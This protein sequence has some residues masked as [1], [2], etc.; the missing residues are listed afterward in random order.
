MDT[1]KTS[2]F[3]RAKNV[4]VRNER[5]IL[6]TVTAVSLTANVVMRTGISQHNDFL[7]EHGLYD[8]FYNVPNTEA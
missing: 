8:Q 7:R 4:Y 6:L 3:A 2:R 1:V 5:R